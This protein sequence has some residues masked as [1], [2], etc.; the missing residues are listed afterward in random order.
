MILMDYEVH[1]MHNDIVFNT[2]LH[3]IFNTGPWPYSVHRMGGAHSLVFYFLLIIRVA[4]GLIYFTL[5]ELCTEDRIIN[6]LHE[7]FYGT[8]YYST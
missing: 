4:T 2:H 8:H 3:T 5:L 7:L 1:I 6:F